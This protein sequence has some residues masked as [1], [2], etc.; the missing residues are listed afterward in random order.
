MDKKYFNSN[1]ISN[2]EVI[3]IYLD[4]Y[5]LFKEE[6][7]QSQKNL[8]FYSTVTLTFITLV[9]TIFQYQLNNNLNEVFVSIV[10]SFVIPFSSLLLFSLYFR[11]N[12]KI[13]RI[14]EYLRE[15]ETLVHKCFINS[16]ILFGKN[17]PLKWE[18]NIV[19]SNNHMFTTPTLM[20][21]MYIIIAVIPISYSLFYTV[22]SEFFWFNALLILFLIVI[23]V[24]PCIRFI[25]IINKELKKINRKMPFLN[26]N[27]KNI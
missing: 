16:N 6:I 13:L 4:E 25:N 18:I 17:H 5:K 21:L 7:I 2:Y 1:E 15:I 26:E 12:I 19:R 3:K 20:M 10:F 8:N 23:S 9:I 24:I 14:A 22:L 11:E 27:I